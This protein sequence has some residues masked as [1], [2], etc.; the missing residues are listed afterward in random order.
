[1]GV[2]TSVCARRDGTLA[3]GYEAERIKQIRI[4]DYRTG[5]KLEIGK[6]VSY[7]LGAADYLPMA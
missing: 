6:P 5:F 7:R 2:P 1:M 4:R 3:V